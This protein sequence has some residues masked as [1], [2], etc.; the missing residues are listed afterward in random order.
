[1]RGRPPSV[2]VETVRAVRRAHA[3]VPLLG[4]GRR[5]AW[6]KPIA[7]QHGITPR[8]VRNIVWGASYRGVT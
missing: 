3:A 2:S 5:R 1:M 6:V 7:K 8:N 4:G